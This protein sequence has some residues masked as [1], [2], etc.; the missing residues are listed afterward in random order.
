MSIIEQMK[1]TDAQIADRFKD[2][3]N[4]SI[5]IQPALMG[6]TILV[7]GVVIGGFVI[8]PQVLDHNTSSQI[9]P[10]F[11]NATPGSQLNLEQQPDDSEIPTTVTVQEGD[12][13]DL[14][15]SDP[16]TPQTLRVV[17]TPD[18]QLNLVDLHG[19]TYT[20]THHGDLTFSW[21]I[22]GIPLTGRAF[23]DPDTLKLAVNLHPNTD[24]PVQNY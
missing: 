6:C 15:D 8:L 24:D 2:E 1:S 16:V 13:F 4:S 21:D 9:K 3:V 18:N 20:S 5:C 14:I 12:A 23:I 7:A 10:T 19:T 22:N 11:V 17:L